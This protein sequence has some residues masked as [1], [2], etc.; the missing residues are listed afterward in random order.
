MP[1]ELKVVLVLSILIFLIY[2]LKNIKRNNLNI[3]NALIWI[4]ISIGI[5]MCVFLIEPLR[6]IAQLAGIKT[7]SNMIFFVGF[8]CLIYVCFNITK[9]T[10]KQNRKIVELTQELA[11]LR[12]E[13]NDNEGKK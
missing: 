4:I 12:K 13:V 3:K 8:V 6:V 2:V 11:L 1:N 5:I 9:T 10:S 7:V